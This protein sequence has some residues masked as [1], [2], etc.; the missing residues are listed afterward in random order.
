MLAPLIGK[1]LE[2]KLLF[3]FLATRA[4]L[5]GILLVFSEVNTLPWSTVMCIPFAKLL[6]SV[7]SIL[8]EVWFSLSLSFS[9][10]M[11]NITST[12]LEF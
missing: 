5:T 7:E 3:L 8:E 9:Q 12:Y 1:D 10:K 4:S 6:L 2:Q 11:L